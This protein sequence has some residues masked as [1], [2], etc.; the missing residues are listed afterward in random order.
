GITVDVRIVAATHRDLPQMV[1][2][3][4]FREDLWYRLATFP[5]VLPPLRE[6]RSDIPELARHFARRA[7]ARFG[8]R[9]QLPTEAD[10]AILCAYNWPGNVREL[11]AVMDRAVIL[12]DGHSLE[13]AK[14]LGPGLT[15]PGRSDA[16]PA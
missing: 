5:I 2:D 6:R 8:L 3:G 9:L 4:R 11:A 7:A 15:V 16:G 10:L 14:A 1:Q 12:G 13:V